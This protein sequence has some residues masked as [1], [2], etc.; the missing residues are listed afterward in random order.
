MSLIDD[1]P[2]YIRLSSAKLRQ[3]E[4]TEISITYASK[5]VCQLRDILEKRTKSEDLKRIV[6]GSNNYK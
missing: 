4:S 6:K 5:E 2:Y 3:T 1:F